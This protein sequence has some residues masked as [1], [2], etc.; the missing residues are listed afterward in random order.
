[1]GFQ[2]K[3]KSYWWRF[4]G[5]ADISVRCDALIGCDYEKE[6]IKTAIRK[7]DVKQGL[8][9]FDEEVLADIIC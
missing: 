6:R 1:M 8:Y 5:S 4:F 7:C 9:N 2:V 3:L